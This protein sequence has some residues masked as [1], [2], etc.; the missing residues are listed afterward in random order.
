M[1]GVFLKK[2]IFVFL[3]ACL[4]GLVAFVGFSSL[5]ERQSPQIVSPDSIYWNTKEPIRVHVAD[6]TELKSYELIMSDGTNQVV[7]SSGT[8]APTLT[9]GSLEIA[10]IPPQLDKEAQLLKLKIKVTDGSF[11][12]FFQGNSTIKIVDI[13]LD[14]TP[15]KV[16]LISH[17]YS[18]TKGGSALVVFSANDMN[19]KRVFIQAANREFQA[20]PFAKD[21]VYAALVAWPFLEE[22]FEA[23]IVAFDDANNRSE[24]KVPFFLKNKT[25]KTSWI[26]ASDNFIDGKITSLA[27]LSQEG[28]AISDRIEKFRYVNETMRIANEELIEKYTTQLS[29]DVVHNWQIKPFYPLRNGAVVATFGDTRY[30]YYSLDTKEQISTSY[31]VG[32]DLASTAQA[33]IVVSNSGK[34]VYTGFNGIYGNMP[35]IDHGMGLFSIYG[36][37]TDIFYDVQ[38]PIGAEEKIATTGVSGLALGD[39]LHFGILV[40]GVEVIPEEWMDKQ[41]IRLNIDDVFA[42][43]KEAIG[44][45]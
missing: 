40:Q 10:A 2:F 17:S 18:V 37:C 7:A 11:W 31:H 6:N 44:V 12:D 24:Y 19:L 32:L 9:S 34:V 16:D 26:R 8:F 3:F 5:F 23:T 4:V 1:L 21:G 39:H 43:A 13:V 22:T 27:N 30:Y 20:V 25:Y 35:I 29:S 14:T 15:P 36:H 38:S 33:G 28:S 42:S 45:K 41:W